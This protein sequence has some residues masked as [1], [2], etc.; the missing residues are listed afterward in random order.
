MIGDLI[1]RLVK[2]KEK[3]SGPPEDQSRV[4]SNFGSTDVSGFKFKS[5]PPNGV[6]FGKF[7]LLNDGSI[8]RVDYSHGEVASDSGSSTES[9]LNS[10]AIRGSILLDGD[11][12]VELYKRPT[13]SQVLTLKR[14]AS[15]YNAK[16]LVYDGKDLRKHK[17]VNFSSPIDSMDKLDYMIRAFTPRADPRIGFC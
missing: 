8:V 15:K 4:V 10:G 7:W 14:M 2:I 13:E 16:M 12:D 9:M 3:S 11:L 17:L 6:K 5:I 1:G